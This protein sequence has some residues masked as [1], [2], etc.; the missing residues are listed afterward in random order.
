[1]TRARRESRLSGSRSLTPF[2]EERAVGIGATK[3]MHV[4]IPVTDLQV[5]VDWYCRLMDLTLTHEFIE[6]GELRGAALRSMEGGFSFA[7]RLMQHCS[8]APDLDGFD[9]VALHMSSRECLSVVQERSE[10]L[11]ADYT[12]VQDRGPHE[13]VVDVTDPDGTLLRFYWVDLAQEPDVFLAFAFRDDGP[14]EITRE[15]RLRAPS[16]LGR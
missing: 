1:V 5:S 9:I 16:V 3:V 6:H 15:P 8:S 2:D 4:K 12:S 10:M 11:G 7:L 14:P 13:A